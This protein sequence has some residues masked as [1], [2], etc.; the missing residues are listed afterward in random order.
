MLVTLSPMFLCIFIIS[1]IKYKSIIQ[2]YF[3]KN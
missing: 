1:K 2:R 3:V